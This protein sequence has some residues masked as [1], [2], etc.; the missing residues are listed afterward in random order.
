[1]K[2]LVI[3]IHPNMEKSR[4]NRRWVEELQKYPDQIT[5]NLLF[6]EYPDEK[7]DIRREQRLLLEHDRVVFQFPFYWYSGPYLL[8][9]WEEEVLAFGWAYGP[10]GAKLHGKELVLAVST[11]G[12]ETA[13][14]GEGYNNFTMSELLRP[15]QNL[16]SL[17]GL[18]Y[19]S[20]FIFHGAKAASDEEIEQSAPRYVKH[21]VS[22]QLE[23]LPQ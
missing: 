19:L 10:G 17:T 15:F 20:P 18:K 3:V 8:Q 7:I 6:Q 12:A 2:T 23:Y 5:V 1:M 9:K 13:Y 16:A 14:R 22:L 4:I 11:G 21:I